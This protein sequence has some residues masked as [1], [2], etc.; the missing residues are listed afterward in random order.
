MKKSVTLFQCALLL[1]SSS[2]LI[3]CHS[4][5]RAAGDII[6]IVAAINDARVVNLSEIAES[7][8]YIPF[9]TTDSSLVTEPRGRQSFIYENE[10]FY[11]HNR[12]LFKLFDKNGKFL[13]SFNREGRGPE[14]FYGGFFDGVDTKSGNIIVQTLFTYS[15]IEYSNKG[16]FISKVSAPAD[17][18]FKCCEHNMAKIGNNRYI[19]T[20]FNACKDM[21]VCAYIFDSLSNVVAKVPTPKIEFLEF[22]EASITIGEKGTQ[23]NNDTPKKE[24]SLNFY[25]FQ[26]QPRISIA[27]YG[28]ILSIKDDN[29]VDT[30]Y[31]INL[32]EYRITNANREKAKA[33]DSKFIH[34]SDM[35]L[36][37]ENQIIFKIINLRG[38]N[39]DPLVSSE[40]KPMYKLSTAMFDKNSGKVTIMHM[41]E[42]NS[43]G[44]KED[45][46]RGP[47]FLPK[48]VSN[49][50]KILIGYV[51]AMDLKMYVEE[52][53]CSDELEKLGAKLDESDNLVAILVKLKE[54]K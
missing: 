23:S 1:F 13:R 12:G 9:E 39:N 46:K 2:L 47:A 19:A 51:S 54:N 34:V 4:E 10:T 24:F 11:T 30:L 37:T 21:G 7:I 3:S 45:L 42:N 53:D 49:D 18:L 15:L 27:S 20:A 33:K 48:S 17:S 16:D 29:T 14:E 40:T 32:G 36:E 41:P 31:K 38:L 22:D 26:N 8:T 5:K 6:D 35:L 52:H 43:P 25:M 44:F 28:Y 50:G